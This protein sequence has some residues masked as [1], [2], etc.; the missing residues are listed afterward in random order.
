MN[1]SGAE[2][3]RLAILSNEI[4]DHINQQ[5]IPGIEELKADVRIGKPEAQINIDRNAAR[6]YEL[7]TGQIADAIRTS[8]FGK[9]VS[10]FKIGEDDYPIQVRLDE[11]YRN[12]ISDLLNQKITFRNPANGQIA[13]VPIS[14]VADVSYSSTYS[15]I[16][17]KNQNR[18]ITVYSKCP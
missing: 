16:K 9:E 14:A 18:V 8:V 13:Q 5:N 7:S 10:K 12:N 17:R 4:I 1:W 11:R 15:S 2:I 3:D 6:R